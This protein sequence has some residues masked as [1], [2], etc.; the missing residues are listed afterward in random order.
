MNLL[1][2]DDHAIFREGLRHL[3]LPLSESLQITEAGSARAAVEILRHRDDLDLVLLDLALPDAKPFDLLKTCRRLQ[4]QVPAVI[5][6]A[7]QERFEIER[8]MSLGAQAYLFKSAPSHQL[9]SA[10]KRVLRGEVIVPDLGDLPVQV[11]EASDTPLT[12]RQL[13]VLQMLARG[14]VNKEIGEAL[15]VSENTVKVHL[16]H[17]YRILGASNRTHVLLKAAQLGIIGS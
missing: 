4:P 9:L 15:G 6:S 3:L 2:I 1:L 11:G 12:T 5:L 7:T 16:S 14:L 8:A 13:E 17:I 10:L